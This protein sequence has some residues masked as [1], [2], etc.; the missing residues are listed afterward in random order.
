MKRWLFFLLV[1]VAQ[2][3]G[4]EQEEYLQLPAIDSEQ[5]S[6]AVLQSDSG[7]VIT[8]T[9]KKRKKKKKKQKKKSPSVF[10]EWSNPEEEGGEPKEGLDDG[11]TVWYQMLMG[12]C[13]Q[14]KSVS[15]PQAESYF[16][17][18]EKLDFVKKSEVDSRFFSWIENDLLPVALVATNESNANLKSNDSKETPISQVTGEQRIALYTIGR[19]FLE[20]TGR[21]V[22]NRRRDGWRKVISRSNDLEKIYTAYPCDLIGCA[23]GAGDVP[24]RL[25]LAT[26]ELTGLTPNARVWHLSTFVN[27]KNLTEEEKK[28]AWQHIDRYAQQGYFSMMMGN[29][30]QAVEQGEVDNYFAQLD[31]QFPH[32][33]I[34]GID[35]GIHKCGD[36][37][38][39]ILDA[40]Q[41]DHWS[42]KAIASCLRVIRASEQ[43]GQ[44]E[45]VDAIEGML[46][47]IC[48]IEKLYGQHSELQYMLGSCYSLLGNAYEKRGNMEAAEVISKAAIQDAEDALTVAKKDAKAIRKAAMQDAVG[49][50]EEAMKR[51]GDSE[52]VL[53]EYIRI[54]LTPSLLTERKKQILKRIEKACRCLVDIA[55]NRKI[56]GL[57]LLTAC[58]SDQNKLGQA[59]HFLGKDS[60]QMCTEVNNDEHLISFYDALL[61]ELQT[62][63]AKK[64]ITGLRRRPA[65]DIKNVIDIINQSCIA[66]HAAQKTAL[67]DPL[68]AALKLVVAAEQHYLF[69]TLKSKEEYRLEYEAVI[70]D[71]ERSQSKLDSAKQEV[72]KLV[73]EKLSSL[74]KE[75]PERLA[76]IVNVTGNSI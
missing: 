25:Y 45:G 71:I 57:W 62:K 17:R 7:V 5:D 39:E 70:D 36:L 74:Q 15:L 52:D 27:D 55:V 73:L 40:Q 3:R 14:E 1:I 68:E 60:R 42:A 2:I 69:T 43:A 50:H 18:C 48:A 28:I 75:A 4:M 8:T 59:A 34:R 29:F 53:V 76:I 10:Y 63:Q 31:E 37:A 58:Y 65:K 64:T 21:C 67:S 11:R 54:L 13:G 30:L 12:M 16:R 66:V 35:E 20:G 22:Q 47:E 61:R 56:D 44:D 46:T 9:K 6:S 33:I 38:Y 19:L 49:A 23:A 26:S 24:S 32:M 72:L 51:A 41:E